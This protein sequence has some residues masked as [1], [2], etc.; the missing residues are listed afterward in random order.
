MKQP[1]RVQKLYARLFDTYLQ[2]KRT[3]DDLEL[4]WCTGLFAWRINAHEI[5]HPIVMTRIELDFDRTSGRMQV[6]PTA[7]LPELAE[8]IF[9]GAPREALGDFPDLAKQFRERPVA[10][11]QRIGIDVVLTELVNSLGTQG[12]LVQNRAQ[13]SGDPQLSRDDL[14]LLRKR[15][16]GYARDISRWLEILKDGKEPP[17]TVRSIVGAHDER[18]AE[19]DA[20]DAKWL[21][22]DTDLLFSPCKRR[23]TTNCDPLS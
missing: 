15:R 20:E 8:E 14:L 16:F 21:G 18:F 6:I 22:L 3:P 4:L 5:Y 1:Y 12:T 11:W 9:Q 10:P 7:S 2:I 17:C 23:T 13:L 19:D